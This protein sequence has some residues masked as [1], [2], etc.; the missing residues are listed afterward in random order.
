MLIAFGCFSGRGCSHNRSAIA[1][2]QRFRT[3]FSANVMYIAFGLRFLSWL[4]NNT[5]YAP[6]KLRRWN[7]FLPIIYPTHACT[8]RFQISGSNQQLYHN[9][10]RASIRIMLVVLLQKQGTIWIDWKNISSKMV[11]VS[12]IFYSYFFY[13]Y[14]PFNIID[15]IYSFNIYTCNYNANISTINALTPRFH[16]KY[17]TFV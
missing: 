16:K 6:K 1:L 5:F 15:I 3:L 13:S 9:M 7:R 17:N 4:I 11:F 8:I 14:T 2:D 10:F 12:S